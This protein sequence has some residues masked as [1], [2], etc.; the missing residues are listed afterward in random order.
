MADGVADTKK[1]LQSRRKMEW[2]Y[3]M[4]KMMKGDDGDDIFKGLQNSRKA[5]LSKCGR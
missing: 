1:K 4:M 3:K 2:G 5:E